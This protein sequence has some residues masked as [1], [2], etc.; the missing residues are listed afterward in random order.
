MGVIRVEPYQ[1]CLPH[2]APDSGTCVTRVANV[3]LPFTRDQFLEVFAAY[4]GAVW[5]AQY[6][7]YALGLAAVLALAS[8]GPTAARIVS[9]TLAAM[10]L[11]TGLAYHAMYFSAINM[12]AWGFAALFV[13]QGAMLVEAGLIRGRVAM[14]PTNGPRGWLGWSMVGY[15]AL[16]YPLLGLALGHRYPAMPMFGITPC[17]VTIFTF[18]M[19]MLAGGRVPRRLLFIP[20]AWS[21]IG[22]SAAFLLDVPQDW[23]L[24]ASG[25][26]V[27]VLWPRGKAR[28]GQ[29]QPA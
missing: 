15:S 5:P 21:L 4:N 10:W 28:L 24:L 14:A 27:L 19:L 9:G 20:G 8:R 11:W 6:V 2:K 13:A 3:M 25:L 29:T 17:P 7:A 18:G 23:L 16:A 26:C 22:G 12:A 1:L